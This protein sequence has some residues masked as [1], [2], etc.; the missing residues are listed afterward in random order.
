MLN[1]IL[2]DRKRKTRSLA[3]ILCLSMIVSLGTF[4]GFH[5]TAI[6][7]VY[8][9][10][11]LDCPFTHEG[12]EP[13]AHVHNDDCYDG[14]TLVCT[15]PEREAHTHTDECFAEQR[16]LVCS[17]EENPGHQH[18]EECYDEEGQLIC[19]IPKGEGAHS[20]TE[21]CYTIERALI[22]N[23]PEL[24]VHI[25]D[26][27]C[28][29]T[30]E[31]TVDEPEETAASEQAVS[32]VPEMPVSDPD[33][34]LETAEDWNRE[35][36]NLELSGNWARD[37]V[38]VAA[39][40][41]GRGESPNNFEAVLND[42]GDAWV[43]HG[44]TRYGAWYGYPYAE[45][46][47]M[48]VSFCLRYAGIPAENVP[49]NPTAALMAESFSM[50]ELFAGRDYV[51]AVG[52]LIFFD[53]V[54]DEITNI[55]HMGIVY[56]V[57]AANG[58]INTVE[59]DRTDAV[60][61][62][63][64]YLNDE[65]IVGYGILPQNPNYVP[66]SPVF[67]TTDEEEETEE[68]ET[69]AVTTDTEDMTV[70]ALPMPAQ[71]WERTAGGIKVSVEAPEGAFPENTTIAVTPVNGNRLKDTVSD[72]VSGEVLEVQAVDITFFDAEG[73]E[74]EPA[75]PIRVSMTPAATEHS[76]E[77]TSVVHVDVAQQ[78]AE[79]IEQAA[80][81]EFDN[82]EVVFDAEA[83]TIYAIV[84]TVHFEYEVD[85][86][87]YTSASMPGAE[88]T[89]LA[90]VIRGLGI[91]SEE[92]IG[93]FV[94][95]ISTV[96][97]TN[98]SVA[99]VETT[100]DGL[101][102]RVLKDGDAQ[103][104]I[105]MQDGAQFRVDVVADGETA[106]GNE[107]VTVSTVGDLYLPA[108]AKLEAKVLPEEQSDSAIAAVEAQE[109]TAG[110]TAAA[111]T[112]YQVF[113]ISL[114]NVDAEKYNGFAV[115]VKL[116]ENVVGRDFRLYHI[117]DGE[118]KE[119]K[120]NTLSR[121]AD[122]TGLEVVSG[123]TFETEDF[124]EFVLKYTVD[125]TYEGRTLQFP[126]QGSYLLSDILAA[127]RIEGNVDDAALTLIQGEDHAGAL[128]LT[129][130]DGEY[131]INSDIPFVDTYELRVQIG[132][133]IY[134]ITVTDEQQTTSPWD[135]ANTNN[136]QF[137]HVYA[138]S[139]VTETEQS[140]DATFK[141]TFTY[142]LEEAVVRAMDSYAKTGKDPVLEYDLSQLVNDSP[143]DSVS[144]SGLMSIGSRKLGSYTVVDNKVIL[145]F[146]DHSYLEGRTKLD[147]YFSLNA[148]TNETELD[149]EDEYIYE[150][151]GT[152]DVIPIHYKKTV[153]NGTKSVYSTK[154]SDGSY[155]L[156]YTANVNVNSD[157]D[158]MV[159]NDT[160]AGLQTLDASSVKINGS[161]VSVTQTSN[162]FSFDVATALGTTGVAKGNYQVTY[163]TTV[164]EAQL[165]AMTADK[166][167]ETNKATWKVN[168]N[169]D[170]PGG[171]TSYEINKPREPIP[172]EK[173][174]SSTVNQP[175]DVVNYTITYGKDTTELSGFR[176]SDIMT[177]VVIPQGKVTLTY[178]GET[179]EIDF[180]ARATDSSYS[181][182]QVPLF[183]HTFPEGTPGNGP[184]TVTYSVKLID[185]DTA[186]ANGIY[187]ATDVSN[188]AQEHRQNTTDTKKTTVTYEKEPTY[189]VN[190][191]ATVTPSSEDGKWAPGTVITYTLT[192]GDA[193][194]NMAG[195]NI[196][197]VMTDL[198]VLQGDIMIRVGN[199]NQMKLSDYV[200]DAI[201]WEDDGRYHTWDVDLFNFNMPSDA[202]N[203]PVVITYTTKVI[204]QEA[205][206]SAGIFGDQTIRNTGHGG[207]QYDGTTGTGVFEDYPIEKTVSKDGQDING[208]SVEMGSMVHYT[209]TFGNPAKNMG[210][211][212]ILD[213]MTD[214]QKLVGDITVKK[215]DG[216]TFTMPLSSGKDA[217][218]GVVW[219]WIDDG[220]YGTTMVRV[221]NYKLPK[222]IGYGPITVEYDTQII[223]EEE[224]NESGIKDTQHVKNKLTVEGHTAETDITVEFPKDPKHNPQVRKEFDHWDVD[225]G[226]IY[227]NII[228]E[229]DNESA[230]PIENVSVRE[231]T[232][233]NE[234]SFKSEKQGV[235]YYIAK[236]SDFDVIHAV[237][238]TDDGTIL[239]PGVDY[240]IDKENA[241]F[242]FPILNERVH[243]NLAFQ[244]DKK[245]IDGTQ[246]HNRVR[247]NNDEY[248]EADAIYNTPDINVIKYGTY[249]E[250]DRLVKWEVTINPSKKEFHDSEP[251]SVIF[252]DYIP[253][254]LILVNYDNKTPENPSIAVSYDGLV[255]G[256]TDKFEVTP[257]ENGTIRADIVPTVQVYDH[258]DPVVGGVYRTEIQAGLD[259]QR[260][261]VTYY[262]KL[263]DEEWDRITS[264]A[265]GS[266]TFENHVTVTAGDDDQFDATDTV[267]VTADEY[268][269]KT[270][271]TKEE[272][273]IVV[274]AETGNASKNITYSVDINPHGYKLN[275]GDPLSL[276]DYI[277]TN[278][279]LI[280]SSVTITNA[281]MGPDGKLVPSEG[282]P[283]GLQMSY[284]DDS[285]LLSIRNI[286]DRT[287]LLLTYTCHARA[288]GEDEFKN[289]ATLIGGG[290]HSSSTSE[291]HKI[292]T[293]DAGVTADGLVINIHKID[294]NNIRKELAGAKFQLYECELTIGSL[295]NSDPYN[296][297]WWSQLLNMVNRRTKGQTTE[298]ENQFI[299]TNFH[300]ERYTEVGD[301]ITTG[302]NGYKEW[303]HISEHK[304]YA[305]KEIEAPENYTGTDEYHYFVA[306]QHLNVNTESGVPEPLPRDEQQRRKEAAWALDDAAQFANGI[307]VA[308][309][310][311]TTTWT[312]TNVES[313]YTSISATKIWENDSDNLFET[314]PTEGIKLQLVRI[315]ADGTRENVGTPVAINADKQTGEWPTHIWNR[316]DSKDG[317]GNALKYT[318]VEEAVEDYSTTYSDQGEGQTA[319][320][321]TVTNHMIPKNT[322]I[323]VQKI[324]EDT[325]TEMPTEI[326]VILMQIRTNKEGVVSNPVEYQT[327]IL[328]TS[329]NWKH[330]FEK[331]PTKEV[332]TRQDGT[333]E[334]YTL[335][336][337]VVED[338]GALEQQGFKYLVSYS[339][340]GKGVIET[341][342][343]KPLVITNR[344]KTGELTVEKTVDSSI[345]S[346]K[347]REFS[348]VVT[349]KDTTVSGTYGDMTFTDGQ[350]T[351]TLKDG[352]KK[353]ATGLPA[354]TE[355]TV[356]ERDAT[357]FAVS[358]SDGT[359]TSN[360]ATY[361]GD[362]ENT[363]VEVTYTNTRETGDLEV[364]KTV[365]SD[366]D[367][368]KETEFAFTV[369]L[370][371]TTMNG[372][373]GD[374]TFVNGVAN[375]NLKNGEKKTATGLPAGI[376]YTAAEATTEGFTLT[377]KTGDTGT[378]STTKSDAK[379]TNTR[380]TGSL[381]ITKNIQTNGITDTAKIGTFYYAVYKEADVENGSPKT[382]AKPV[383]TDS[384]SVTTGGTN[385]VTVENLPYGK[386][387]VYELDGPNGAPIISGDD[388]MLTVIRGTTYR[389]I[390]SGTIATVG[391]EAGASADSSDAS[392]ASSTGNAITLNNSIETTEA[393][394]KKIWA[395]NG[396]PPSSLTVALVADGVVTD[397]EVTLNNSNEWS[398]KIT[399]LAKYG[400]ITADNP[401]IVYT[402][403]EKDLP[404]GYFLT[405]S[406]VNGTIT[407]LTNTYQ[408][409]DLKTSYVGIKYWEDENNKYSTRPSDLT[410]TLKAS[411]L[412]E[413]TG[414]YGD[415]VP[416]NNTPTWTKDPATNQWTYTFNDLPVFDENGNVIKYS[417]QETE[418][419]G[420]TGETTKSE[421]T[422]YQYGT[423]Y[424]SEV[425][426]R[427]T[428]G[429]HLTWNL[430]SLIDMSFV[431]IKTTANKPTVV[432]THRVPTPYEKE[433][434]R[435]GLVDDGKLP[436]CNPSL[437]WYS[438]H[439]GTIDTGHGSV[440]VDFD[441]ESLEVTLQ[442]GSSSSWSQYVYGHF[443]KDDSSEYDIGTTEFTNTLETTEL[444]GKKTWSISG[445]QTPV[446]PI[447]TLTRT[448]TTMEGEGEEKTPKTSDPETVTMIRKVEE[449]GTTKEEYVNLQPTWS[450]TGNTRSF[451]YSGLPKYDK[452]GNEYTY[453][454][455]EYQFTVS[456]VTYTVTKDKNGDYVAT[457]NAENAPKFKVTQE[458][459][460]I[461]NTEVTDF[462]FSKKWL[463]A[464]GDE[465]DGWKDKITVDVV[466]QIGDTIDT[467]FK[468][469]YTITPQN[470]NA[471]SIAP[472]EG[473]SGT[474]SLKPQNG[475]GFTF[476]VEDLEKYGKI[477]ETEG[478]FTYYVKETVPPASGYMPPVYMDADNN[479]IQTGT[480][481]G[482]Q[483][484]NQ[485][486]IVNQENAGVELPET[487]GI[488]TTL[489]TAFGGL[490]TVTA[491]AILTIQSYRRRSHNA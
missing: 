330:T 341:T 117:H 486:S 305:W 179:K 252:E 15:L 423:I 397:K 475:T 69:A 313:K 435:K 193:E 22:C 392:E 405:G 268:I 297:A 92:E 41:Q 83:F 282:T 476:K 102:V 449:G 404:D 24:P 5:K 447:L 209:L 234:V 353:T 320:T 39:T 16:V 154:N 413:T 247:L 17:L 473:S 96:V 409:Y 267:T 424:W 319:G 9:R 336:Y 56:H 218:N 443:D 104:V 238:T 175:G 350:A 97:S 192:I 355:Y 396:T 180:D 469:Q 213:E 308:S 338:T 113:D 89:S 477:A 340:D 360:A 306:Y 76:E 384:I 196:K 129:Q 434:I 402:W 215:A 426:N 415:P 460:S 374:M 81:T 60:A 390:G 253:N 235:Y 439:S 250:E 258:W 78:T 276:T 281:V 227:W 379:F 490:M 298:E 357:G 155:T 25:H 344:P 246:M 125:F 217:D 90:E 278:M 425:Q 231:S 123:F 491:G 466:R 485:G 324:F 391:A 455:F 40:Q 365:I 479:I 171:E 91:V 438:G 219:S 182:G 54:N 3:L 407:S 287:P 418:P 108:E 335:S 372:T 44:Y 395:G 243:I 468:L 59:G 131:F 79:L 115:E 33:A 422:K 46:D 302:E 272:G 135:L 265:S 119:I 13:V 73:H 224:A 124:S 294:E 352:E 222:D 483:A 21:E 174:I 403:L 138:D 436:G 433:E 359:T 411:Y 286:P 326:K 164:T 334:V 34:D 170:V 70:P 358:I 116:P 185:A 463:K 195:V 459:N 233:R 383:K 130:S 105:T 421:D 188:V 464:G 259:K 197:D 470:Y 103:I 480:A 36:E 441:E 82:S 458:E 399:G 363:P 311:N 304:L 322:D 327:E 28:F 230:Y 20:H 136:T 429:D 208:K 283:D 181:K 157:L 461:T 139:S 51:P 61:T 200:A 71:S 134:I 275:N 382:D 329:N 342:A 467:N 204:G 376:N 186:K 346:D 291:K 269:Y 373:Y 62:F 107:T 263:S 114:E 454:V 142:S 8:T 364:S 2:K 127:L 408:T 428:P 472:A 66:T 351:F 348:F 162:G 489:F 377:G 367:A 30:E 337:T 303:D 368:D 194:T 146:T 109:G 444:N 202:G 143:I 84:Y 6:A 446:D 201:K 191:T 7:K 414:K 260:Y 349:L 239:T 98:E 35:F 75:I 94:S 280:T 198:Q 177:D 156:H 266:E 240:S 481:N 292:Q 187:D 456:G 11:I 388:G 67:M 210:E 80:G 471:S 189:V 88:Y 49:N 211:I 279:D 432:W 87:T 64:Y 347:T 256:R 318:V 184:V 315:N 400:D 47:A 161:S 232:D 343:D 453:S 110:I 167:T 420:Y 325:G 132:E 74:I 1:Q 427:I 19:Q 478:E 140:R 31:I 141:L 442:F 445:T 430:G 419:A 205:A 254:G 257:D 316:L 261:T 29:R 95:K 237:V 220:K 244:T 277:S 333:K 48:F 289:T 273:G 387:Y 183:D 339:D 484:P 310:S 378:I 331:L 147:G 398:G 203:G 410:V 172:V 228:V 99:V 274:D 148:S 465:V 68:T 101:C 386:Y 332:V 57:D 375:F 207:K 361:Q 242:L 159:F 356:E 406:S 225:A 85:G 190:K 385:T 72:A 452:A 482:N 176:I 18:T 53:T 431:A 321:I 178:N 241:L 212:T 26:A 290:S 120:L 10:E 223:S 153:E 487:G 271:S 100:E 262:T 111:E 43:R 126:G 137:L 158:S 216:S 221:F 149:D 381:E 245:I 42:A 251:K 165:K 307:I 206:T 145:T 27:G 451:T 38:L 45:W 328:T 299:D 144:G 354:D 270:D 160:L 58:T 229:K 371:D 301:P 118:T 248:A 12:A 389:V 63:G 23:Q 173:T 32:T 295:T 366:A 169:K 55:D 226:K 151:P 380:E 52:D 77:K 106:A 394:V 86:E 309:L 440:T 163:D 122:D 317:D 448:V 285:R 462:E 133:K 416:L 37:L 65:Q 4:A 300:I 166:T 412:N 296:D 488:G 450:G 199:G 264:S 312:A 128:Y 369:T 345:D 249:T 288:Q 401:E 474:E 370:S 255:S 284:N 214:L 437:T 168:G 323:H 393:E 236:A 50:G 152:T 314:R 121:P 150:F 14:E 457:P 362:F 112:A 293:T 417:A 93:T